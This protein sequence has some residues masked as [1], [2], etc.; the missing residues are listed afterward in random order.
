MT[1]QLVKLP[2]DEMYEKADREGRI[3]TC[4]LCEEEHVLCECGVCFKYCHDDYYCD[5]PDIDDHQ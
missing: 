2:I 5:Y 4:A 3:G 1:F